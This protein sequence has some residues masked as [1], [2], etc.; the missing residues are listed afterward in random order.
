MEVSGNT[1]LITGGAT[2]I[3][4]AMAESFLEAG[5]EVVICGRRED[6]LLEA[7]KKH[8]GLHFKALNVAEEAGRRVLVE[9]ITT[10][11]GNLNILV[12]NAGVQRDIDFTKGAAEFLAGENEIKINLE[13]PIV[14][15]GL[16][17]PHLAGKKEAAIINVSSGLGF[18]PAARMPVYSATKAGM[19]AFSM[20]LRQQLLKV[21]IK[22]FE[23]VPP[24]VDTELNPEGR[25]KRSNFKVDLKP[26]EYVASVMNGLKN[27]VFEIGYA[28]TEGIIRASRADL[29]KS[30]QQMNS[31]W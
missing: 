12:N 30:F 10:H 31:R 5:N 22:V 19:H 9:W 13:S 18:V 24:A 23:V 27:D 25:A 11:F 17:I 28:M 26:A 16:F 29:D 14:L 8:K 4:Y 20:A 21:G 2:G 3:G 15:S 7:Q 1:V 6:R